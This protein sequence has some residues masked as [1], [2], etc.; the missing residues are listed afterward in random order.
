[1]NISSVSTPLILSTHWHNATPTP[2][3]GP[4]WG[5]TGYDVTHFFLAVLYL[6]VLVLAY[7]WRIRNARHT[8]WQVTFAVCIVLGTLVRAAFFAVQPFVYED[9][10]A[11]LPPK[12]NLYLNVLPT[13]PFLSCYVIILF[14]WAEIYHSTTDEPADLRNNFIGISGVMYFIVVALVISDLVIPY[15]VPHQKI[16]T[17]VTIS[18]LIIFTYTGSLYL[19]V[20][21]GFGVYGGRFYWRFRRGAPLLQRTRLEILPR[22]KQ[23]T[24]MVAFCFVSRGILVI[25]STYEFWIDD[26]WWFDFFYYTLLEVI[27]LILMLLILKN[28]NGSN[29]GS[30]RVGGSSLQ[31]PSDSEK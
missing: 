5:S 4:Q 20:S 10:L 3:V 22:V 2:T 16:P 14:L 26:F 17:A 25:L 28:K 18:E 7:L 19:I 1:M 8:F 31:E 13:Y 27:P 23:L 15:D 29:R 11:K 30:M 21:I 6:L 24:A 9:L 12:L